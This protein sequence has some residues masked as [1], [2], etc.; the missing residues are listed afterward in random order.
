MILFVALFAPLAFS[1]L[2]GLGWT[3]RPLAETSP[4]EVA[5]AGIGVSDGLLVLGTLGLL[6]AIYAV[7]SLASLALSMLA[8]LI[9]QS[10]TCYRR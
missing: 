3:T 8:L 1:V 6:A 4:S 5:R 10:W 2:D 9:P 7:V